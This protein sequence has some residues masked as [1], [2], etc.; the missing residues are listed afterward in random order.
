MWGGGW[1]QPQVSF[2][3]QSHDHILPSGKGNHW[4]ITKRK[5]SKVCIPSLQQ[6]IHILIFWMP[7]S[8]SYLLITMTSEMKMDRLAHLAKYSYWRS[9]SLCWIPKKLGGVCARARA[10]ACAI[11]F[12]RRHENNFQELLLS[13]HLYMAPQVPTQPVQIAQS[14]PLPSEPSCLCHSFAFQGEPLGWEDSC[15]S[16]HGGYESFP[17]DVWAEG[18]VLSWWIQS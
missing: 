9:K 4:E 5:E 12:A 18:L 16:C 17:K 11:A 13:F 6:G 14:A 1:G 8:C 3:F 2:Q 10:R 7:N 15:A